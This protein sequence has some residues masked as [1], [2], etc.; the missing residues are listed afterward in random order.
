MA[1]KSEENICTEIHESKTFDLEQEIN[2]KINF[3]ESSILNQKVSPEM[4]TYIKPASKRNKISLKKVIKKGVDKTEKSHLCHECGKTFLKPHQLTSHLRVHSGIKPY[5]CET[6]N[7]QVKDYSNFMVHLRTH[8][9]EASTKYSCDQCNKVFGTWSGRYY[10]IKRNHS[11]KQFICE[12]CSKAFGLKQHLK[13]HF[14]IHTGERPHI[15]NECGKCF[16]V[17]SILREH[18]LIHAGEKK[19]SCTVCDKRFTGKKH[20]VQHMVTHTGIR[21]HK[22]EIC[23]KAFT[24]RHV[25]RSHL[26]MHEKDK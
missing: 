16:R 6:C 24:Q 19:F 20:V 22:C 7:A 17:K 11:P 18:M 23:Q 1:S 26:K 21:K 2:N 25:L 15:C 4:N 14:K 13:Q 8:N 5:K 10:H 3:L 9:R 12:V